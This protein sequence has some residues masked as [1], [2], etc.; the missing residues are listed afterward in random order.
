MIAS[1]SDEF[2]NFSAA[3]A[4]NIGLTRRES[5]HTA[6]NETGSGERRTQ[7]EDVRQNASLLCPPTPIVFLF[8]SP[9]MSSS[10]NW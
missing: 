4:L 5:A 8:L 1:E 2:A 7:I 3:D 10:S 9:S 6:D